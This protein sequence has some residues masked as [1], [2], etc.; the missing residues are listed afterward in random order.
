MS[1]RLQINIAITM[2]MS[3][4]IGT[5][6]V[7]EIDAASRSMAEEMEAASRVTGLL[8]D[9]ITKIDQG[10]DPAWLRACL[11]RLGRVRANEIA[12]LAPDGTVL[13]ASPPPTY[14]VGRD[15]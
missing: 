1:L 7:V 9:W 10:A 3:L 6:V 8:L 14:K 15:A 2:L 4:F 5:L 11:T 12:L 13:Y